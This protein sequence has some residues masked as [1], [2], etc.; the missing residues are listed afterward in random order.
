MAYEIPKN[1]KYEEKIAFGLTF[2]QLFWIG[3]FG[4]SAA[5]ILFKTALPLILKVPIALFL[6]SLAIGFAFFSFW[7]HLKNLNAY[8]NS[9][10]E[11]G[12][13]DKRLN[14]F[15][16]VKKIEN[17]AVYLRDNSLRAIIQVMPINFLMLS[18][19]EQ[20]AVI[21]AYFDFLNSLDFP[22][23]IVVRTVNLSLDDYLAKLKQEV[24]SL[25]KEALAEQFN[26]F[27]EFV[28]GFIKE[29]AIKNRLFYVVIPYSQEY[30][31]NS[32]KDLTISFKN[33]FSRE[34]AKTSIE[35][36]REIALNGLA[37]RA[38]LCQEKLARCNLFSERL[39]SAQLTSLL[40]SFFESFVEAENNYFFPITMLE[41]FG[42]KEVD[43][44]EQTEIA[45][46]QIKKSIA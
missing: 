34:K 46:P 9:I 10:H 7:Q 19:E 28:K 23:Q 45:E 1:L 39:N 40:A 5:I 11:A 8:K 33:L 2:M 6:S 14:E 24:A 22:V 20:K 37:V 25:K 43:E 4:G 35:L 31:L 27:E 30:S 41:K 38:K 26:S 29:N 18:G 36:N 44:I 32:L 13:F 15:V 17:N 16:E 21:S 3:L 42:E 12:Y